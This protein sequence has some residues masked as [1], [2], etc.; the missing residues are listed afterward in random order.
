MNMNNLEQFTNE[1]TALINRFNLDNDL[2]TPDYM[3]AD[4]L[5]LSMMNLEATIKARSHWFPNE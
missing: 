1:L 5:V 2:E 4:H 3:V